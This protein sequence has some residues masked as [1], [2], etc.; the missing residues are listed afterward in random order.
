LE[1]TSGGL[2]S[3]PCSEQGHLKQV[4]EA[5]FSQALKVSRD[6][7]S[8]AAQGPVSSVLP[9]GE[10]SF[11]YTYLEFPVLQFMSIAS[12]SITRHLQEDSGFFSP[13][14]HHAAVGS[15]RILSSVFYLKNECTQLCQTLPV[16]QTSDTILVASTGLAALSRETKTGENTQDRVSS[17][18]QIGEMASRNLLATVLLTHPEFTVQP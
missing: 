3:N 12:H 18:E 7:D 8:T 11:S 6:T 9:S 1:G 14:S 16:L 10:S 5:E 17:A 2:Q 15:N 13:P 4:P